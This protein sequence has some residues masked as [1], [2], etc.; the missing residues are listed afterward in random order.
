MNHTISIE[1][2]NDDSGDVE[3]L[4]LPA[5]WQICSRC[6]G[7]GTHVN[8][9]IDGHGITSEEWENDWDPEEREG[10][11]RGDYDIRC[12]A[13]CCD[14]KVLEIDY[15]RLNDELKKKVDEYYDGQ[16]E[17]ARERAYDARIRRYEDGD[18]SNY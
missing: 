14:G 7:N 15:E 8:P 9:S 17:I 3:T 18:Y 1:A 6:N 12:D 4:V 5:K 16:A 11:F 10:Y 2:A 13:G